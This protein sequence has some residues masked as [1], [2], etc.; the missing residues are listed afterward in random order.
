MIRK[1]FSLLPVVLMAF[2][3]ANAQDGQLPCTTNEV[4]D[5]YKKSF[6][7]IE[8]YEKQLKVFIDEAMKNIDVDRARSKGTNDPSNPDAILHIP[9]VVHVVHDYGTVDYV[10]DDDVFR[11]IE[12]INEV[13][14]KRNADT[15]DVIAPFKKYI[16]SPNIMFHLATKDPMGRPTTG[17]THRRSYLTD[18]GDD[19]AKF[20][21]WDP[22]SYLNIWTIR[23]IGRGITNGVVAAYAV[24]PSSA[25]AFP[26]TD[27]IITS[28]GSIFSNKTIPHEIG[29]ILSLFHT[30]GNI[31]VATRCGEDDEIDDTP[32]TTGHFSNGNP[33][34][35]T[36]NGFCN[37]ASLYDTSCTNNLQ[38]MSK[39]LLDKGS[40]PAV[41]MGVKGFD[42][43]PYTN[44]ALESVKI[45]PSTIGAEF[46]IVNYKQDRNTGVFNP[47][48]IFTTKRDSILGKSLLGANA[49]ANNFGADSGLL[50]TAIIF[51]TLKHVWIDSFDIYP[52]TIGDTFT[53]TLRRFNNNLV[54][55]YTG[56]T[57]TNTGAQKVPFSA[58]IPV[59][60]AYRLQIERNPGLQSDS[61]VNATRSAIDSVINGAVAFT[62]FIDTTNMDYAN[63]GTAYKGRY[64]FFYNWKV[65]FD[66]LTTTDTSAQTVPLGFKVL[67]DTTYRLTLTKNP[68][69]YNDSVGNTP[70][71]KS[72][73]CVI[74]ITN[75]VT[76]GRYDLLYDLRVRYGYIKNCIDYPDTVNTQN[77]MDYA[78]CP[79]MFTHLQVARMR[80]TLASPV[81]GRNNLINEN[82]HLRTGILDVSGGT[83]G[84]RLDMSPVP[85]ISIE[86]VGLDPERN[87][88]LCAGT[89][90]FQ[91]RQRSW[92][93]TIQSVE[94]SFN[95]NPQQS[96]INLTGPS[97]SG[98]FS[99]R[100]N[101]SGWVD[102]TVKATGNNT[103]D[104]T[105]V[106]KSLVY[107]ADSVNRIN[108]NNGFFMDFKTD[109]ANNPLE[110]WPI[111]NYYG[112]YNKWAFDHNVGYWDNSCIV[113]QNYDKRV[114]VEG[115]NGTPKGDRD[116]FFTP[117]FDLS[118]MTTGE[119]RLNFMSSGAFRVSD[120]RLMRDTLEISYSLDCGQN[121][122]QLA[123]LTKS[124]LANKGVV[125]IE[126]APLYYGDWALKSFD[127]PT[128]ARTE[129]VFFRFRFKPGVDD[130]SGSL[131][132]SRVL[133]GTGNNFFIDR[134]N[135]SSFK[136]GANTL[137][138]GDKN[139]AIAPNP[140]NGSTQLVIKSPLK[141]EAKVVVTDVAGK[142]VYTT[143]EMLNGS[144]TSIEIPA[145]AIKVKGVY[146]VH[147]M[148]GYERYTEKL[149]SY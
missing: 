44:L 45:Y 75:D 125:P 69:V 103:A 68:G 43:Q 98:N 93:D 37:A 9:V 92:R 34:G 123:E 74:D 145:S 101:E 94:V 42:Y 57:T 115:Y 17:I 108:P 15:I 22:T 149:V 53:V 148:A 76:A 86:R 109:D 48:N 137:L 90:D 8:A 131:Q 105:T 120:S 10:S 118:G 65:R 5:S 97:L 35:A 27:G 60:N 147:V 62:A 39:I 23:R 2:G 110:K 87:Y 130:L 114:G 70:Y 11:L 66:A 116:D 83:Y 64:N 31:G 132:N 89:R 50:K 36:A 72:I 78:N 100:F 95:K 18:G 128:S 40:K 146:M 113:Y 102:V 13:F 21:Q 32:P 134:I 140:T 28:A 142:V 91:F 85:D 19:Q 26:Y 71:V 88:F 61:L 106:F 59:E 141:D 63:N 73:P 119:C 16:G 121:W 77:I 14:M 104:S 143:S 29:H 81:G 20:D 135:I 112:N 4:N 127:I 117:A 111:F 30:W 46:E 58:F 52:T 6:P 12:D 144:I 54:K 24:F 51:N 7:E 3:F 1:V 49:V 126:Y 80:A 47:V 56:V 82:T 107:A 41:D 67:P 136:L 55:S 84:K 33:F 38:S 124:E 139:V 122:A 25:G 96:T 79:L 133:P 99:N 138:I 129:K